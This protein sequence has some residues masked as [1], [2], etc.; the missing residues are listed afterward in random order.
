MTS[1]PER[2]RM[3]RRFAALGAALLFISPAALAGNAILGVTCDKNDVGAEVYINGKLKGGC[4]VN[5]PISSG[6]VSLHVKK[7]DREF[8]Q[9]IRIGDGA[10]EMVHA[11][12]SQIDR[13]QTMAEQQRQ[14]SLAQQALFD[15]YS[16]EFEQCLRRDGFYGYTGPVEVSAVKMGGCTALT[17][18][19][20]SKLQCEPNFGGRPQEVIECQ[21]AVES[22][23]APAEP[24]MAENLRQQLR[25]N[26]RA[27]MNRECLSAL[28]VNDAK[29]R[30]DA[31]EV[32]ETQA[33][34]MRIA[35]G[36]E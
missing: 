4:P 6:S 12:M 17:N 33:T 13:G 18:I 10:V 32:R 23:R 29:R 9:E 16:V 11:R 5:L 26:R 36:V 8:R 35:S 30:G 1:N 31:A 27:L 2:Q 3:D 22:G 25:A 15:R 24:R 19:A 7:A 34:C 20:I 14:D 21:R 28:D